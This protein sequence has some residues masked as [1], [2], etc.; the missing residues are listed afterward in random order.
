MAEA[1]GLIVRESSNRVANQVPLKPARFVRVVDQEKSGW[2]LRRFLNALKVSPPWARQK[3]VLAGNTLKYFVRFV[4]G[5]IEGIAGAPAAAKWGLMVR[6]SRRPTSMELSPLPSSD[7]IWL[8]SV[9]A[10]ET[11][12]VWPISFSYPRPSSALSDNRSSSSTMC[13]VFPG[14]SYAFTDGDAY[15]K[16]YAGYRFALTHKK[17]GW[18]CFRHLEIL[19]AGAIP[20]MP[21]AGLIPGFT[22]V[23]YPKRLFSEVANQL[24]TAAGSLGVDVR[25]QLIDY[26]NQN[27]TTEAMARYFLKAASPIP[28]PKILFIDQAAVDMPDYQSILTLIGLKQILGNNVSVAFPTG[29]LYEDWSEDTTKLYGRG[30]GYTRVLDPGLKNPNEIRSTPL[31]LS[32]SAL[33]K[34]DLVVIGSIKRNEDLAHQL[35]GRFPASKTIWVNGEDAAPS[36][37][38][39]KAFTSLGVT[40]FVRELTKSP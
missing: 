24:N 2:T 11:I 34:F 25:K 31:S 4:A 37:E 6:H 35:L 20:Y 32:T 3:A 14:H 10:H 39:L 27:L 26:F 28:K 13:P 15:I 18:D 33:S 1:H 23:H 12:G 16:T 36:Q 22:M 29:Y 7:E 17:G 30:F 8:D 19:Y 5:N 9:R 21:D 38:E 40:L